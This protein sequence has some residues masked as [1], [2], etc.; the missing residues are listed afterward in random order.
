MAEENRKT[1]S[2]GYVNDY[3]AV[4]EYNKL[5]LELKKQK[6]QDAAK[7]KEMSEHISD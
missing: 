6:E 7:D 1:E 4:F 3:S 2:S 5:M